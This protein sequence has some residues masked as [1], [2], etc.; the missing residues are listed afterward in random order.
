MRMNENRTPSLRR[1]TEQRAVYRLDDS[2]T[3]FCQ[4]Q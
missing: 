4:P 2:L 3:S 1:P